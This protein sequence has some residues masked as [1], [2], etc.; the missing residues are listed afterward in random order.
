MVQQESKKQPKHCLPLDLL[1]EMN[2][3]QSVGSSDKQLSV[4]CSYLKES[5]K[6]LPDSRNSGLQMPCLILRFSG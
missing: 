1:Y 5:D 2:T 6:R 3:L 4:I